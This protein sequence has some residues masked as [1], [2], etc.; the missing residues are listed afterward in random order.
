MD[1]EE[2]DILPGIAGED[3]MILEGL[4]E[5]EVSVMCVSVFPVTLTREFV[6]EPGAEK[7]DCP[8]HGNE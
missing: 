3:V 2:N 7:L 4:V 8:G 6:I 1:T 5:L